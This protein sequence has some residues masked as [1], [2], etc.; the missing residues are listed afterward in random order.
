[1]GD[2][3]VVGIKVGRGTTVEGE[4][5]KVFEFLQLGEIV[6]LPKEDG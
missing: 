5:L 1:L 2:A 6:R 4:E 3:T